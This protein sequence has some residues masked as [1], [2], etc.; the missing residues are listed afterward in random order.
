MDRRRPRTIS[1]GAT[2]NS[3]FGSR[4]IDA[5]ANTQS[6][7]SGLFSGLVL[8][9]V[10]L[11]ILLR[12]YGHLDLQHFFT[13]WWPLLIIFWG[14]VKLYER[15][16]GRRFGGGG[17]GITAGEVFLVL[18]MFALLGA[19]PP[20]TSSRTQGRPGRIGIWA[21]IVIRSMIW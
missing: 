18:G 19:S 3:V 12:N 8:I 20:W 11:L 15:T 17:G 14:L 2:T 7:S 6:R 13:H 16:A 9:T 4:T 5:M 21:A 10:G 1:H